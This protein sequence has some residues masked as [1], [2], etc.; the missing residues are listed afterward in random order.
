MNRSIA[1]RCRSTALLAAA[2]IAAS[3]SVA[4]Q[5]P[6]AIE[7]LPSLDVPGYMGTWYQVAL[8]PNRFQRQCVSDTTARYRQVGGGVDVVNRCRT[9]DGSFVEAIGFA[10][11]SDSRL[12]NDRLQPARLEVSFLPRWLRWLPVWGRYWVLMR[13]DDG[14]YA[15]VSEPTREYL[16]VLSRQ[17]TLAA[18]DEHAIRSRLGELGFDLGRWQAHP[19]PAAASIAADAA[20]SPPPQPSTTPA[21][22]TR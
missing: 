8:F 18:A 21:A 6:P 15:V 20:P 1:P 2:L 10:R 12:E 7:P 3:A 9:A 22:P 11:T 5:T 14:R 17:P 13:A 19:Q 16:W 4:A